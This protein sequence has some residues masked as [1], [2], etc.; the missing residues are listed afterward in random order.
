MVVRQTLRQRIS[1]TRLLLSLSLSLTL[2]NPSY[3]LC[4][5][6][7]LDH[8]NLGRALLERHA[9]RHPALGHHH[10][11]QPGARNLYLDVT[12]TNPMGVTNHEL[13]NRGGRPCGGRGPP[14]APPRPWPRARRPASAHLPSALRNTRCARLNMQHAGRPHCT[15]TTRE[16][17]GGGA[18]ASSFVAWCWR[19]PSLF[20]VPH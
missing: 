6:S 16:A 18:G 7:F 1:R 20:L 19:E 12:S 15:A 9:S 4:L 13:I 3:L 8:G 2:T 10:H 11:R 17:F 14:R 5:S